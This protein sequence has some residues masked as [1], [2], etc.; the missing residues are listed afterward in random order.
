MESG[1]IGS[2]PPRLHPPAVTRITTAPMSRRLHTCEKA[3]FSI[4]IESLHA[5]G[6]THQRPCFAGCRRGR[7]PLL[8]G[9]AISLYKASHDFGSLQL[10]KS[11]THSSA[12][13]RESNGFMVARPKE[14]SLAAARDLFRSCPAFRG[15]DQP[16]RAVVLFGLLVPL[17]GCK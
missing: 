10:L 6:T 15:R 5:D 2:F 3:R 8:S 1:A 12:I 11:P 9:Q 17:H 7:S 16:R 4:C 13:E 14:K